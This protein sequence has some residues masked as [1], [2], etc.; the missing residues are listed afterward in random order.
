VKAHP[1]GVSC[2][3]V[4]LSL[5]C[6][7]LAS[8]GVGPIVTRPS[9]ER[10]SYGDELRVREGAGSSG[11]QGLTVIEAQA[12]VAVAERASAAAVGAGP[13]YVRWLGPAALSARIAPMLGAQYFDRTVFASAGLHAGLGAGAVLVETEQVLPRWGPIWAT[14]MPASETETESYR[15]ERTLLTLELTFAA[16]AQARGATLTAGALIGLA[17][18]EEQRVRERPRL[19]P[20]RWF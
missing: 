4:W 1:L 5:G 18:S 17:W 14:G 13:A 3:L 19:R 12:R 15:R 2:G 8:L 7:H 16:D 10:A 6:S 9:G 20:R 11:E